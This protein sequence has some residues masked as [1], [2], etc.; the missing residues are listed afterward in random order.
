TNTPLQALNLMNDVTYVEAAR[1]LAQRV[2]RECKTPE[3]RLTRA[4]RLVMARPPRPAEIKILSAN[5]KYQQERFDVDPAAAEK[6]VRIGEYPR[7][8]P[9][10]EL[11]AYMTVASLI[12]N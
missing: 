3:G 8:G 4:F 10:A 7:K 6:L 1:V 11:A 2:L 5:L 12:L 9:A